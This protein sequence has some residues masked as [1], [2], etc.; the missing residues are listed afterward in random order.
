MLRQ[1][2]VLGISSCG[3]K[4]LKATF[5]EKVECWVMGIEDKN[6]PDS[7]ALYKELQAAELR[8]IIRLVPSAVDVTQTLREVDAVVL[9]SRYNGRHSSGR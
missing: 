6:R 7:T 9:P 1:K 3:R 8:G 5:G 4:K 2:G